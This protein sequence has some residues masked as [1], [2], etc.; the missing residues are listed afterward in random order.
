ML[1]P[2]RR[3]RRGDRIS[4]SATSPHGT[5]RT[6]RDGRFHG[7][8]RRVTGPSAEIPEPAPLT[9]SR[10]RRFGAEERVALSIDLSRHRSFTLVGEHRKGNGDET[11]QR[12]SYDASMPM[13]MLPFVRLTATAFKGFV[14]LG[15]K[16]G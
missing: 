4:G 12:V 14:L 13:L 11:L 5:T 7:K 16:A 8:F 6:S 15:G 3:R 2:L 10:H 1:P 9:L